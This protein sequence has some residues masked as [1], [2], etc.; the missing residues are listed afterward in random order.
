MKK[1]IFLLLLLI[2]ISNASA[3]LTLQE[4]HTASNKVLVVVFVSEK[5]VATN[6]NQWIKEVV[7]VNEVETKDISAWKLNGRPPLA[8]HKFVTESS[9]TCSDP[10][11]CEHY[12]YLEIPPFINGTR[13]TLETP[14]GD[15]TFVFNDRTMF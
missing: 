5:V 13:Y 1:I 10:K 15:K 6:Y 11:G 8:I 7:D 9:A 4:I 2:H 12:I 3:K 14:H